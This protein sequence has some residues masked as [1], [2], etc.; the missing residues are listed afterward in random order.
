MLKFISR[1]AHVVLLVLAMFMCISNL[2]KNGMRRF[3]ERAL[4]PTASWYNE[5]CYLGFLGIHHQEQMKIM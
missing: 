5:I 3:D 1:A 4:N 2:F